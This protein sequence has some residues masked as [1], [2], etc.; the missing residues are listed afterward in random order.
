MS[1]TPADDLCVIANDM[2][3][4]KVF[5]MSNIGGILPF[6][7]SAK[8]TTSEDT[9]ILRVRKMQN[10][11]FRLDDFFK[12]TPKWNFLRL[13]F[14]RIHSRHRYEKAGRRPWLMPALEPHSSFFSHGQPWSKRIFN[15]QRSSIVL[16]IHHMLSSLPHLGCT[17]ANPSY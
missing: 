12:S 16:K 17:T 4:D 2:G 8:H 1:P 6:Y 10:L 9:E 3:L 15:T 5:D 7:C 13:F 11:K 14:C